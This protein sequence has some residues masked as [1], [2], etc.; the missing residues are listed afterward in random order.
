MLNYSLA[1]KP[2]AANSSLRFL[3]VCLRVCEWKAS[4]FR[5][6][7]IRA[8]H[9]P[10]Q[11]VRGFISVRTPARLHLIKAIMDD[12]RIYNRVLSTRMWLRFMP[13]PSI[14]LAIS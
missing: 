4:G 12:V 2:M 3:R 9:G 6:Q 10:L 13:P 7:H 8:L 11:I 1:V 14:R 5:G